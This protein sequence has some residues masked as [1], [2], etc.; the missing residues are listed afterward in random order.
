MSEET[1]RDALRNSVIAET[2]N[3]K[4][5]RSAIV[6]A[7]RIL[8]LHRPHW[9]GCHVQVDGILA[10]ALSAYSDPEAIARAE[11]EFNR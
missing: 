9:N 10:D 7:R 1:L 4:R 2:S 3:G 11:L 8:A 5:L 6:E